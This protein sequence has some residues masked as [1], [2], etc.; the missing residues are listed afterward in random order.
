MRSR[1]A[2]SVT[3]LAPSRWPTGVS[4]IATLPTLTLRPAANGVMRW[5]ARLASA[6]VYSGS[7]LPCLDRP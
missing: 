1:P 3:A 7:A 2:A 4:E 5:S 6:P